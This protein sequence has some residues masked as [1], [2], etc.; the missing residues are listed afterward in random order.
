[1]W[2]PVAKIRATIVAAAAALSMA[3]SIHIVIRA[4]IRSVRDLVASLRTWMTNRNEDPE[5]RS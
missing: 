4:P 5:R 1:M 3:R 2:E